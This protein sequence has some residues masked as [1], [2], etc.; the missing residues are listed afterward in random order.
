MSSLKAVLVVG[1]LS[2]FAPVAAS[3]PSIQDGQD[4]PVEKRSVGFIATESRNRGASPC[5]VRSLH[6]GS[7]EKFAVYP[8]RNSYSE[9]N[10]APRQISWKFARPRT[11]KILNDALR[12][13]TIDGSRMGTFPNAYVYLDQ[14]GG[15][16]SRLVV[17]MDWKYVM[18][19]TDIS[20][21][22]PLGK[23]ARKILKR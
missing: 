7:I 2:F 15:Q 1:L 10:C 20:K 22:Y 13:P 9:M 6:I 3:I 11:S 21:L 16:L 14:S 17:V 23:E 4:K 18:I 19:E 12:K 5:V 8:Y